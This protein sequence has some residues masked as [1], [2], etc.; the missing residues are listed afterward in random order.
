MTGTSTT[1]FS[2]ETNVTR[3]QAAAMLYRFAGQPTA[4]GDVSIFNDA[5]RIS[6]YAVTP[7]RWAVGEGILNGKSAQLL[8]PTGTATRAEI[9]KIL[10]VWLMKR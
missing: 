2:P 4:A 7:L 1:T 8:D 3:E 9:A 10:T 6:G 5:N